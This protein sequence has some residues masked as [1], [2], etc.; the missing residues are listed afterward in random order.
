MKMPLQILII[1]PMSAPPI[2][3]KRSLDVLTSTCY[4]CMMCHGYYPSFA[5][6]AVNLS[7][8]STA[9]STVIRQLVPLGCHSW[10]LRQL[11]KVMKGY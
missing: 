8:R 11:Q 1:M 5:N 6:P 4:P 3:R 10:Q 9:G 7:D 2:D